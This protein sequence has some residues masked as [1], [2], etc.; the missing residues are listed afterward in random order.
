MRCRF[1]VRRSEI[2]AKAVDYFKLKHLSLKLLSHAISA[3]WR[4]GALPFRPVARRVI[5][6]CFVWVFAPKQ[7][8]ESA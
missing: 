8:E 2:M 4:C 7:E 5:W 1:P 6:S 3:G